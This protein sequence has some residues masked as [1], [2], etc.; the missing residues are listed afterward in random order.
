MSFLPEEAEGEDSSPGRRRSAEVS[1]DW[2][3]CFCDR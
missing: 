2:R 3:S 1:Q